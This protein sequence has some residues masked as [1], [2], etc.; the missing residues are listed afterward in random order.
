MV[1]PVIHSVK[2]YVQYSIATV[3]GGVVTSNNI[4]KS[5][6]VDAVDQ[7]DEVAE[8]SI[9]KAVYFE[10]WIRSGSTTGSSG[11]AIIYKK[12]GDATH[13]SATDMA[14]LGDWDN[15]KNVLYTTMG[16]FND[17]DADAQI[18][19]KGWVKIPKGKQRFGLGDILAFAVYTPT[20]DAQ[21]CGFATYKEYS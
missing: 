6:A 3:T 20:I 21:I 8:G 9:I 15:K 19:Y 14:A 17:Q 5:V 11:Q 7:V 4:V 13:P 10:L 1:R 2:H 12:V 18:I 16:L